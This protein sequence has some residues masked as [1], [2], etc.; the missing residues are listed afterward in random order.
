M[1]LGD[2][3]GETRTLMGVNRV[4]KTGDVGLRAQPDISLLKKDPFLT[5]LFFGQKLSVN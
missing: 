4:V 5:G 2:K 1:S 3:R